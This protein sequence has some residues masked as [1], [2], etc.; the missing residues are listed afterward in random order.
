[1]TRAFRVPTSLTIAFVTA[2]SG[3]G[4]VTLPDTPVLTTIEVSPT[5]ASVTVGQTQ[6]FTA[7]PRDR[8]G[9][10]MP[11]TAMQWASSDLTVATIDA[12]GVATAIA[13]GITT[14]TAGAGGKTATAHLTVMP[15]PRVVTTVEVGA[16]GRDLMVGD[17]VRLDATVR[18]QRGAIMTGRVP[19]WS[20]QAP[21]VATVDANGLVTAIDAGVAMVTATVDGKT[22]STNVTVLPPVAAIVI[23][24]D[25][26]IIQVA[27]TLAMH[28]VLRDAGGGT[29]TG[30]PVS[31]ASLD[32]GV[33]SV[34]GT[35]LVT[36]VQHG[37]ARIVASAEGK[38][39][40]AVVRVPAQPMVVTLEPAGARNA[41]I[42]QDGGAVT[43]TS[44]SGIRY[45]LTIPSGALLTAAP[46]V[47]T[48]VRSVTSL[49]LSGGFVAGVEFAPAG[50]VFARPATLTIET[51]QRPSSGQIAVGLSYEGTTSPP[52][53]ALA[54]LTPGGMEMP[55]SHF[56]GVTV[57][58]G[59]S[60]DLFALSSS[61][62]VSADRD[63]YFTVMLTAAASTP[64]DPSVLRNTATFWFDDVVLKAVRQATTDGDLV[65]ALGLWREWNEVVTA[66]YDVPANVPALS[67][68]QSQWYFESI[69]KIRA[70]MD[71][72]KLRCD[73]QTRSTSERLGALHAAMFWQ[74]QAQI[75]GVDSPANGLTAADF[76]RS[77]C[78]SIVVV[79]SALANPLTE[80]VQT[81]LDIT[82]GIRLT[83][84]TATLP[85]NFFLTATASGAVLDREFGFT[86]LSP[87]GFYTTVV[88]PSSG[89]GAATITLD[90]CYVFSVSAGA[91]AGTLFCRSESVTRTVVGQPLEWNFDDDLEGW[92][93][94]GNTIQRSNV[95]NRGVARLDGGAMQKSINLPA[96]V[97]TFEFEISA[98]NQP[99]SVTAF[100]VQVTGPSGSAVIMNSSRTAPG[101]GGYSWSIVS[102]SLALFAG[103]TVTITIQQFPQSHG[104]LYI[105]WIRIR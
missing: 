38:A 93:P 70:A 46:I 89:T 97:T 76:M 54:R 42:G 83:G 69:P 73:D 11:G 18:D 2:C 15:E 43:V 96:N 60:A 84:V 48:P 75:E 35:G 91:V 3:D 39:D 62:P 105:D 86:A 51:N 27:Q 59:T 50:L 41:V 90:A 31:W 40:T 7:T 45:T 10:V 28:A 23:A 71:A 19:T 24:P 34:A 68:L 12:S 20:S 57:G 64:P 102:A 52:D 26:A 22:G 81:S 47:L 87:A 78:A 13:E 25:S 104:Q 6:P 32:A 37:S 58:F 21:S 63:Y 85:A 82:F 61:R 80:G 49:P 9:G 94:L 8:N 92:T 44:S 65:L 4:G 74:T 1:M 101:G 29:I 14:I 33:A 72:D 17:T 99:S 36:A 77:L 79:Q 98:H 56:S 103:Q 88:T 30:R 55:V 53:L 16:A 5:A 95:D 66:L 67:I 100:T